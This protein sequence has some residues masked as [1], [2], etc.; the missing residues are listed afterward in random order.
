MDLEV[1]VQVSQPWWWLYSCGSVYHV[2]YLQNFLCT[3][4]QLRWSS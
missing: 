2:A 3:L 1:S 4:W